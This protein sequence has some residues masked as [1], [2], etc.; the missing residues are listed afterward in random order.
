MSGSKAEV[1]VVRAKGG[2]GERIVGL[3]EIQ[4]P[5]MWHVAHAQPDPKVRDMILECWG[6]C[7]DLLKHIKGE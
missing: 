5:D 2:T 6:L 7:H 3:S 4:V 1:A